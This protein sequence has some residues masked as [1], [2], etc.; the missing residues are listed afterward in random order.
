L[1]DAVT[2]LQQDKPEEAER[3][4]REILVADPKNVTALKL[5]AEL[6]IRAER[7]RAAET[8]LAH[9]LELAPDFLGARYRYATVLLL[10]NKLK[11]TMAQLNEL[12]KQD[13]DETYY[14]NLKAVTLTRMSDFEGAAAEYAAVLK[15]DPNQPGVWISYGNALNVMGR[16]EEAIAAYRKPIELV[17]GHG[18]AYWSL[19]NL[20]T[21][22]FTDSDME[23]MFANLMRPDLKGENRS[24]FHFALG[25]ALEDE[26]RFEEAFDNYRAA[27]NQLRATVSYSADENSE[28]IRRSKAFFTREFFEKRAG[29]G[30]PAR[31]PIF[32]VGLPRSG[33]TLI[34]QILASHSA[35]EGTTELRAIDYMAGR[36]GGKLRRS[37]VVKNYPEVLATLDADTVKALG[38]EYVNRGKSYR[39]TA[40][41][42]FIDKMPNNFLHL[43]F[44][45]LIVP[46]AKIIDVR[47]H[48]LG[49]CLSNYKQHFGPGQ[50]FS[51]SLTDLG[52]Y[53]FDYVE[54]MAHYDMVLPGRVHRVIYEELI[55]HPEQEIRRLFEYLA[56]PFEEQCLRFYEND[57][58]VRTPSA[59]QVRQPIF[60]GGVDYWKHFEPWLGPLKTA[61]GS[62]LDLY[63]AVPPFYDRLHAEVKQEASWGEVWSAKPQWTKAATKSA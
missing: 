38:E 25:K 16:R 50:Y 13:P 42:Y 19:A 53:Y 55:E 27:N 46:N 11:M 17:P 18:E 3:L 56:M 39:R 31:D 57:R 52:R 23:A 1:R 51:Y 30:S 15:N 43:G 47:R 54:L 48:P 21:F 58:P 14:C 37:D 29:L 28:Q 8:L 4:L 10:Q 60:T 34:E 5:M 20:K 63:P 6:C 62:V 7:F 40:R 44:I 24:Y 36:L 49:C 26:G 32:V 59:Q 2:F 45:H 61:L 9:C 12:S 41:P 33:S 22:R 35:I